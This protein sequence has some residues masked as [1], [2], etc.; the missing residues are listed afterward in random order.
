MAAKLRL[1]GDWRKR[2][3]AVWRAAMTRSEIV[4]DFLNIISILITKTQRRPAY[5]GLNISLTYV[6]RKVNI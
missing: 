2:E 3:L 5:I 4:S 6:T 1:E